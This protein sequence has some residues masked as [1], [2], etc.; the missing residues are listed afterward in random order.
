MREAAQSVHARIVQ[1]RPSR[2]THTGTHAHP[3]ALFASAFAACAVLTPRLACAHTLRS[4][5]IADTPNPT[6]PHSP[7]A[8]PPA[9]GKYGSPEDMRRFVD[10]AHQLGLGVIIDVVLHHG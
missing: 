5:H 9:A 3:P 10:R 6:R 7:P 8:R 1:R 4:E 2:L